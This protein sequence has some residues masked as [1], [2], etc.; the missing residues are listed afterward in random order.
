[1]TEKEKKIAKVKEFF[2]EHGVEVKNVV[3]MTDS[4]QEWIKERESLIAKIKKYV[5]TYHPEFKDTWYKTQDRLAFII[6]MYAHRDQKRL[7]G[8]SYIEHPLNLSTMLSQLSLCEIERDD[9]YVWMECGLPFYGVEEVALLHDVLE[10]TTVTLDDI[11]YI[12][13]K[14]GFWDYYV[15]YIEDPLKLI[16]HNKK[17]SYETYM[18]AVIDSPTASLVKMLDMQDNINMFTLDKLGD[19]EV[20]RCIK[21]IKCTKILNDKHH[22]IEKINRYHT[23]I[24]NKNKKKSD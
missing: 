9:M 17:E 14:Y 1:M 11:G 12:F 7:N 6:A 4:N 18:Q 24:Q 16:T 22:F 10:D 21:Y 8:D 20:N 2:K 13:E 3:D 15:T 5:E 19:E 23:A